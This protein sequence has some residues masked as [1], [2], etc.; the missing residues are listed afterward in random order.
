MSGQPPQRIPIKLNT[1]HLTAEQLEG[2]AAWQRLG[3]LQASHLEMELS[4]DSQ[5]PEL[6]QGLDVLASFQL[7]SDEQIHRICA[8][9][10]VCPLPS[11]SQPQALPAA[12]ESPSP[13]P[14]G[15]VSGA[16]SF[17]KSGWVAT[18]RRA[19]LDRVNNMTRS[20]T[21]ELMGDE[22]SIFGLLLLGVFSAIVGSGLLAA[23]LW[24]TLPPVGQYGILWLY[25]LAF[26]RMQWWSQK[27]SNLQ[28]TAKMLELATLL[29]LPVN[30]WAL[31]TLVG[32]Q[33]PWNWLTIAIAVS[34][35]A[36]VAAGKSQP[37]QR[38]A[39][40]I[41]LAISLLHWGWNFPSM[42]LLMAYFSTIGTAVAFFIYQSRVAR[43]LPKE[44]QPTPPP[45]ATTSLPR[46]ESRDRFVFPAIVG[47][48]WGM[49]V[50]SILVRAIFAEKVLISQLGLAFGICGFL[51]CWWR[52]RRY[53]PPLQLFGAILLLLGWGVSVLATPPWQAL[54]VSLLA[55]R[56]LF[57][58]LYRYGS[59]RD[60]AA[61]II[62]ILQA[63]VLAGRSIPPPIQALG[64]SLS[65][66]VVGEQAPVYERFGMGWF[67]SVW[68]LLG[69]CWWL[70]RC[71]QQGVGWNPRQFVRYT[72][73]L[74]LGFGGL[75]VLA[76]F[77]HPTM[78]TVSLGMAAMTNLVYLWQTPRQRET[79]APTPSA[80][81][82]YLSH[83][84]VVAA[85]ASA[86]YTGLAPLSISTW[87]MVL[88]GGTVGEWL[89]VAIA[90]IFR[91]H[92]FPT[93][94]RHPGQRHRFRRL[95][96]PYIARS[97]WHI[98]LVFASSSYILNFNYPDLPT[99][100]LWLIVP[101][102]LT[103]VA[104]SQK[105]ARNAERMSRSA[106]LSVAALVAWQVLLLNHPGMDLSGLAIAALLCWLNT[107]QIQQKLPANTIPKPSIKWQCESAAAIDIAFFLALA[108]LGFWQYFQTKAGFEDWLVAAGVALLVLW[109]L[110]SGL[111]FFSNHSTALPTATLSS[112]Y[113]GVIDTWAALLSG[114]LL[115]L[116]SFY[117]ILFFVTPN[118]VDPNWEITIAAAIATLASVFRVSQG[119]DRFTFFRVA[120][121][122]EVLAASLLLFVSRSTVPLAIANIGLGLVTQLGSEVWWHYSGRFRGPS[123]GEIER[124]QPFYSS[125]PYTSFSIIPPMYA[126]GGWLLSQ[127]WNIQATSGWF[128][129]GMALVLVGVGKRSLRWKWWSY[130]GMLAVSIAAYQGLLY[131]MSHEGEGAFGDGL[132]V[133]AGLGAAI[134]WA[135]PLLGRWIR[136]YLGLTI[137]EWRV[138]S[139][140]HWLGSTVLLSMGF[141]H[142]AT[143]I[144]QWLVIAVA[145]LLAGYAIWQGHSHG[146]SGRRQREIWTYLGIVQALVAIAYLLWIVLPEFLLLTFS[147]VVATVLSTRMCDSN[148]EAWGWSETPW[149]RVGAIAPLAS[150]AAVTPVD[151]PSNIALL[152]VAGFYAWLAQKTN[153]IRISYVGVLLGNVT[154]FR[155]MVEQGIGELLWYLGVVSASLIYIAQVD[156][157][158][159]SVSYQQSRHW[160]RCLASGIF[161]FRAL[162]QFGGTFLTG[163]FVIAIGIA[164]IFMGLVTRIRAYL[165]VGSLVFTVQIFRH[166]WMFAKTYDFVL[167][168]LLT[169]LGLFFIWAAASFESSR[170]FASFVRN[171]L[172]ELDEWE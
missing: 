17:S 39:M 93:P 127:P 56:L 42:P 61:I 107:W 123:D 85:I 11:H 169:L 23:H 102:G 44:R 45:S 133:L 55:L 70:Y 161:G 3:L 120:W 40:G 118:L 126:I 134:A 21:N 140:I 83:G 19:T 124:Q 22:L 9:Y 82:V 147:G 149:K 144:G 46:A 139:Q 97:A 150:L 50:F 25:T 172:N 117:C 67:P 41:T 81:T 76:S 52:S 94:R 103:G 26:F 122:V 6:L 135:Y 98:G 4:V 27:Q 71:R 111:L 109:L 18:I 43:S 79:T 157:A 95:Q 156:P 58:R 24:P 167:W 12:S 87:S 154:V 62:V 31:D 13:S 119:I 131:A 166:L 74:A 137:P 151:W 110:R 125:I 69:L 15:K 28:I 10:L 114:V 164:F 53:R 38:Q 143:T 106:W 57:D 136:P 36:I 89:F 84:L 96:I 73:R 170:S 129:L 2:L 65:T 90:G 7:L 168:A 121:A 108:A 29:L 35:F 49:T 148:W 37:Q 60:W 30:F 16:L 77:S 113:I 78:R 142:R 75:V 54:L 91:H 130:L 171:K 8:L 86:I 59:W 132:A 5:H 92:H 68:L 128:A 101:V 99:D 1:A 104:Q 33:T 66:Q 116:L 141:S 159:Q 14:T 162:Y 100:L 64:I 163:L 51:L 155:I 112:T 34:S 160:L 158:L 63:Y 80:T 146:A 20:L 48:S 32:W 88:I 47:A 105:S 115:A 153:R 152:V 138:L 72:E 165:Y 145:L